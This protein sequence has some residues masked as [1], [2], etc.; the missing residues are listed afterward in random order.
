MDQPAAG[1]VPGWLVRLTAQLPAW[2]RTVRARLALTYSGLLFLVA[3]LL[4][5]GLYVAL[6]QTI[7]AA[8]LDPVTVKKFER[9]PDGRIHYKPGAE[10]QAADVADVQAYVNF[11]TLQTLRTYSFIALA[12]LFVLSLLIG[13]WVAGR[14]LRPVGAITATA[15]EITGSDLSRRI[16]ATGPQDELR[17]LADT[18]DGMLD[19][20]EAAFTAQRDLVDDVS[21]ELRNPVAVVQ[22]NLD[23]VLSRDDVTPAERAQA[24]AVV[25]RATNRMGGL[26]EDLLA[27]ARL[28]SGA[29]VERDVDLSALAQ[30]AAEEFRL[31]ASS[32]G[33]SLVLRLAPGPRVI[34]DP[35][36]LTRALDNLLSNAVRLAPGGSEVTVA[37]GSRAGWA[38]VA[39]RDEG[40]G[41]AAEDRE[42][43]FDRF[44][45]TG[46]AEG[47]GEGHGL[48]LAIARQVVESHEG[49]IAL[50]SEV[51]V[52]STFVVWLPDRV[53][54]GG[55][56]SP[57]AR[58]ADGPGERDRT[59]PTDDPL[60]RR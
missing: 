60:G 32:R 13:W 42:R 39:V 29:F 2:A 40:P 54:H 55:Q 58:D 7:D 17:T 4:V 52:G 38:W 6:A 10:F 18:L 41:I 9:G 20:L 30:E 49:R 14:A 26:V 12:V 11:T 23:A 46:P 24:A 3:A 56:Q 19:R 57:F 48:G 43:V 44:R 25:Q 50:F 16:A 33:V 51:G 21:H 59:P 35:E 47:N 27:T 22:A 1:G 37:S 34:A 28:R 45:R 31:L 8:P 36:S 15:R 5:G 53:F